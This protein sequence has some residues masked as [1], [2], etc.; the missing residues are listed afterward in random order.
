MQPPRTQSP[1]LAPLANNVEFI[2]V[3]GASDT[4]PGWHGPR[5][6][7]ALRRTPDKIGACR[8]RDAA[9]AGATGGGAQPEWPAA[10][11]RQDCQPDDARGA[12][13]VQQAARL[14]REDTGVLPVSM[15]DEHRGAAVHGEL[16]TGHLK[17]HNFAAWA[18][19]S[20]MV[21]SRAASRR[22]VRCRKRGQCRRRTKPLCAVPPWIRC[23][24]MRHV[25][26]YGVPPGVCLL[27][28]RGHA[29]RF[30]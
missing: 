27:P 6:A 26:G 4:V 12:R 17:R 13:R 2:S 24:M 18:S 3:S 5:S 8:R 7:L 23:G 10:V 25:G 1:H 9:S 22:A 21:K 16:Q 30:P 14:M 29:R 28:C 19:R 15:P 11:W 20:C